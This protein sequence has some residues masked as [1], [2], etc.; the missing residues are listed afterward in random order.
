MSACPTITDKWAVRVYHYQIGD[1]AHQRNPSKLYGTYLENIDVISLQPLTALLDSCKDPLDRQLIATPGHVTHLSTET[2][3]VDESSWSMCLGISPLEEGFGH[4]YHTLPWNLVFLDEFTE[5]PLGVTLGVGI[6]CVKGL[7]SA[8]ARSVEGNGRAHIDSSIVC[9][10]LI[11]FVHSL[12]CHKLTLRCF[13][14]SSSSRTHVHLSAGLLTPY[15]IHPRMICET[16]RPDFPRL[17]YFILSVLM[18]WGRKS[19]FRNP[20]D[21]RRAWN[22]YAVI[23]PGPKYAS[24]V[25]STVTFMR[26]L[27]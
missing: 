7:L 22:G 14:A 11:S 25:A 17:T 5:D 27:C 10:L 6:G 23:V 15:D 2:S 9:V 18:R 19:V 12:R 3:I 16:L 26:S 21:D 8:H 20:R 4:N 24:K 1:T 13:I